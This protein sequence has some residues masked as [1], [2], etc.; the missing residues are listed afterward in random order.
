MKKSSFLSLLAV[1]PLVV[2]SG[3]LLAQGMGGGMMGGMRG[4]S[5]VQVPADNPITPAKVALGKQLYFD[6]RLSKDGTFGARRWVLSKVPA[7]C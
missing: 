5:G 3:I 2:T 7:V 6:A 1:T 4:M